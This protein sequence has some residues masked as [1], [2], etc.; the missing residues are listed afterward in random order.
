[1]YLGKRGS[2]VRRS[3]ES[4]AAPDTCHDCED[5]VGPGD[6]IDPANAGS[7]EEFVICLRRLRARS[8]NISYRALERWGNYRQC[9]PR[10]ICASIRLLSAWGTV[11]LHSDELGVIRKQSRL[12]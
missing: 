2:Q 11:P 12:A 9:S 6:D 7:A 3:I 4:R 5:R 10:D 8:G 1:M